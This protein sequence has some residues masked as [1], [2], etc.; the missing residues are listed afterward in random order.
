M[1]AGVFGAGVGLDDEG[2]R[3]T[4]CLPS[5]VTTGCNSIS[6]SITSSRPV[7]YVF[8]FINA[9]KE[10]AKA[11]AELE[12]TKVALSREAA[13][14]AS[15]IGSLK[16][17][18][19]AEKGLRAQAEE[20]LT[21][22]SR[23][24]EE[25]N[26]ENAELVNIIAQRDKEI[27]IL[28]G[29]S[30]QKETK[31]VIFPEDSYVSIDPFNVSTSLLGDGVFKCKIDKTI[32]SEL[33]YPHFKKEFSLTIGKEVLSKILQ[34][35][36]SRVDTILMSDRAGSIWART[37]FT[38]EQLTKIANLGNFI[39]HDVSNNGSVKHTKLRTMLYGLDCSIKYNYSDLGSIAIVREISSDN[40]QCSQQ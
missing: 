23:Q 22:V 37:N 1:C 38:D 14:S 20:M 15:Q 9:K 32:E 35:N 19:E 33:V 24:N 2:T 10:L 5:F 16:Q 6:K 39:Y 31:T 8:S 4:S 26:A 7:R 17:Q 21:E 29:L 34:I 27:E 11:E 12:T 25:K 30:D 3:C 28:Q 36:E 18:L 13:T 40:S